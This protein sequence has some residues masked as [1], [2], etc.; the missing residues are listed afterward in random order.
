M[1]D[2]KARAR[3]LAQEAVDAYGGDASEIRLHR[4][5]EAVI[6]IYAREMLE[7]EPTEAME[8]AAEVSKPRGYHDLFRAMAAE[9]A[10][11]LK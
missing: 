2:M 9:L 4:A 11:E 8:I 3:E 5:I 1:T 7:R 6:L 10:K